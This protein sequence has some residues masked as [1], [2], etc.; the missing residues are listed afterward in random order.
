[1]K[2]ILGL[3]LCLSLFGCAT[4]PSFRVLEPAVDEEV[5]DI[6]YLNQES[7]VE[8]GETIVAKGKIYSCTYK[9]M[10][11]FNEVHSQGEPKA[12]VGGSVSVP[13]GDLIMKAEDA[14]W[15]YFYAKQVMI[16]RWGAVWP[17]VGGLRFSKINSTIEI[18]APDFTWAWSKVPHAVPQYKIH[19]IK[20]D[21][22]HKPS[23]KQELIYNGRLGNS[24]K[25][26]YREISDDMMRPA[27][28]QEIQY[29]L[30]DGKTIGFKGSRIEII[31]ASNTELRYKVIKNFP[32]LNY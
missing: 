22:E 32:E 18:F 14:E 20:S 28:S 21:K 7:R 26:L 5:I 8:L 29:D 1:M 15:E 17:G 31:K 2:N 6:P 3:I 16:T 24:V 11:L 23:F 25:F 4:I 30:N 12:L 9:G 10:T 19:K 27:F 13:P